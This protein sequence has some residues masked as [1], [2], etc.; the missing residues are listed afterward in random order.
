MPTDKPF[1]LH[2]I[3]H[4]VVATT[5]KHIELLYIEKNRNRARWGQQIN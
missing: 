5:D 1:P 4:T 2:N 3:L